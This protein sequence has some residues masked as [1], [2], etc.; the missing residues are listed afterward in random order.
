MTTASLGRWVTR[1][2][3]GC[4]VV[5]AF[6]SLAW[7]GCDDPVQQPQRQDLLVE[8]PYRQGGTWLRAN[9]HLHSTHSHGLLP[10]AELVEL[11]RARGYGVIS[12]TDHNQYGDQDGGVLAGAFQADSLLHD[13]NGDGVTHPDHVYGS[14]VEAYVRDWTAEPP[15]YC[16]D[17]WF[18]P[19][20][21]SITAVPL[22]LSGFEASCGYFGA[23]FGL[24]GFPPGAIDPPRAGFDWLGR[25]AVAGGFAYVAHPWGRERHRQPLRRLS[26]PAGIRWP[27]DHQRC[28]AHRR[29]AGGR[30]ATVGLAAHPG[31]PALGARERRC[32]LPARR[33]RAGAIHRLRRDSLPRAHHGGRARGAPPG[34]LL[35]QHRTPWRSVLLPTGGPLLAGFFLCESCVRI[36]I[37][38]PF[39]P[40]RPRG[41]HEFPG[42]R[43]SG[44]SARERFSIR[45]HPHWT[46]G[47]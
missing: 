45:P 43:V 15:A 9:L 39:L 27:G 14:G 10:A 42:R 7:P 46:K 13:W 3:L 26:A 28:L 24:V 11:Y 4:L 12:I 1:R 32:A 6:A 16:R 38:D 25:S 36:F 29:L 37:P 21:A 41:S 30:N 35:R 19:A 22:V 31:L 5:L 23:H 47:P 17:R 20:G 40:G 8:N 44:S 34:G 2:R 33:G 18:R